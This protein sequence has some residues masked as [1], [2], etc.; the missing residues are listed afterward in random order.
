MGW[1]MGDTPSWRQAATPTAI[2][3]HCLPLYC[4]QRIGTGRRFCRPACLPSLLLKLTTCYSPCGKSLPASF[5][6]GFAGE[7]GSSA[8]QDGICNRQ[9]GAAPSR[10]AHEISSGKTQRTQDMTSPGRGLVRASKPCMP[11]AIHAHCLLLYF[12][13]L[14]LRRGPSNLSSEWLPRL[15]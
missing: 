5:P 10:R 6:D 3:A 4:L 1:D 13:Q 2:H 14:V 7:T 8:R 9:C 15:W 12:V 11:T